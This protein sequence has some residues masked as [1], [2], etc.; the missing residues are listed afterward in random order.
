MDM[1][2]NMRE[3]LEAFVKG[4]VAQAT[5]GQLIA[6][7]LA[8]TKAAETARAVRQSRT[9]KWTQ[10]SGVLTAREARKMVRDREAAA[11]KRTI[12]M[13][14]R[15]YE[16]ATKKQAKEDEKARRCLDKLERHIQRQQEKE[17]EA[18]AKQ[19]TKMERAV[20]REQK[21]EEKAAE[22]EA[23]KAA[24]NAAKLPAR[25]TSQQQQNNVVQITTTFQLRAC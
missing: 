23:R 1:P 10:K 12:E 11:L 20:R 25:S 15:A 9:K 17:E 16:R 5:T 8:N 2:T 4:N 14:S 19:H 6:D 22:K 21:K 7:N 24:K 3:K 13:E 18:A